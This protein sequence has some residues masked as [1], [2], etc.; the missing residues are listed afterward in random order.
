M[1][2]VDNGGLFTGDNVSHKRVARMDDGTFAGTLKAVDQGLS[3]PVKV[4]VPGHGKSGGRELL[5]EQ[6]G[7]I[8]H[9]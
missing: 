7:F 8:R 3:L 5:T 4:V 6:K 9:Y 1:I 2:E